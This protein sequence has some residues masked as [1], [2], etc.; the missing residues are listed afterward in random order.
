MKKT[1]LLLLTA[2]FVFLITPISGMAMSK[3]SDTIFDNTP[4]AGTFIPSP[5]K[6]SED[7]ILTLY[8]NDIPHNLIP[9]TTPDDQILK[10]PS[11][12]E[13]M[14]VS[15][16]KIDIDTGTTFTTINYHDTL[17]LTYRTDNSSESSLAHGDSLPIQFG[18]NYYFQVK[19]N[20]EAISNSVSF[21]CRFEPSDAGMPGIAEPE[22]FTPSTSIPYSCSHHFYW[23]TIQEATPTQDGLE[24]YMCDC[25]KI[26]E[27][28]KI[29]AFGTYLRQVE[30][31]ILTASPNASLKF[32]TD[33]WVSFDKPVME[34]LDKR[35]DV[36]LDVNFKYLHNEYT[37]HIPPRSPE[38]KLTE[39]NTDWY[40]YLYLGTKNPATVQL[41][42]DYHF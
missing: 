41:G 23:S 18:T 5:P 7:S 4:N 20:S 9:N 31:T 1:I 21:S 26:Q 38:T 27:T 16:E 17:F 13:T 3:P 12:A 6:I 24:Y 8:F 28:R 25:G 10:I 34:A 32:D 30:H 33:L 22:I 14:G 11:L 36:D 42:L 29:S 35:R 15:F 37:L 39:E 19:S 2:V 40:G